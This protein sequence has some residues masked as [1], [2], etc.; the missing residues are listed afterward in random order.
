MKKLFSKL[1][2]SR[3]RSILSIILIIGCYVIHLNFIVTSWYEV[4][5]FVAGMGF[6]FFTFLFFRIQQYMRQFDNEPMSQL[7]NQLIS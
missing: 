3:L 5:F 1:K 6:D 2:L 7:A 4:I